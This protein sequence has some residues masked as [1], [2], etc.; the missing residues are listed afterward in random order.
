MFKLSLEM[1]TAFPELSIY[2]PG[3]ATSGICPLTVGT[4]AVGTPR[5]DAVPVK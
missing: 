3:A 2:I 4:G 1:G 5:L